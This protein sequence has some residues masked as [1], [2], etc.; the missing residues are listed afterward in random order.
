MHSAQINKLA[1][2]VKSKRISIGTAVEQVEQQVSQPKSPGAGERVVAKRLLGGA[3]DARKRFDSADHFSMKQRM[4][5]DLLKFA[6]KGEKEVKRQSTSEK[7]YGGQKMLARR[8]LKKANAGG[9]KR[10][11][12]ADH[13]SASSEARQAADPAT[14]MG[15]KSQSQWAAAPPE[16]PSAATVSGAHK[17][18]AQRALERSNASAG[19]RK[20]FDS[21]DHYMRRNVKKATPPSPSSSSV[22][23]SNIKINNSTKEA[24]AASASRKYGRLGKGKKKAKNEGKAKSNNVAMAI[25]GGRS[26]KSNPRKFDSATYF[27]SKAGDLTTLQKVDD[28]ID[29]NPPPGEFVTRDIDSDGSSDASSQSRGSM[30]AAKAIMNGRS[31]RP[32]N[33][34]R[35]DSANYFMEN[36]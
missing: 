22:R 26:R 2:A 30:E 5:K 19:N 27:M 29:G 16:A 3:G 28:V 34:Q 10:F 24:A 4:K 36:K 7:E 32:S 18:L 15:S 9:R 17:R 31:K 23:K 6:S 20:R 12:S 25:L 21:A 14:A 35:F 13:F 1:S 8:A 11:D 33:L